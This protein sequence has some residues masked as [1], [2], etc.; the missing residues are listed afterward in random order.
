MLK[1]K[2]KIGQKVYAVSSVSDTRQKRVECN[3]C[4]STGWVKVQGRDED[5][6]CP[7]C[8]GRIE[9]E[10]YGYTKVRRS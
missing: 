6:I 7:A 8:Q 10:R 9:T 3:V 4:N 1:P 5:F 2:F